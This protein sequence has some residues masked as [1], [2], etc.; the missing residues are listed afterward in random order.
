[1]G[2][3]GDG[4]VQRVLQPVVQ[5]GERRR[6]TSAKGL[7]GTR[8]GDGGLHFVKYHFDFYLFS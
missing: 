3:V 8:S 7:G 4:D 2:F 5:A 6:K 1:V